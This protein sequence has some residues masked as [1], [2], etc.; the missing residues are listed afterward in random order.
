MSSSN[1]KWYSFQRWHCIES[2]QTTTKLKKSNTYS[3]TSKRETERRKKNS[4][5]F[6]KMLYTD[7]NLPQSISISTSSNNNSRNYH[8]NNMNKSINS[9][10]SNKY[11]YISDKFTNL[12][13]NSTSSSISSNSSSSATNSSLNGAV[14][15]AT[16]IEPKYPMS[17]QTKPSVNG[18]APKAHLKNITNP[19]YNLPRFSYLTLSPNGKKN[20]RR[21]SNDYDLNDHSSQFS[22]KV[23]LYAPKHNANKNKHVNIFILFL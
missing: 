11:D 10:N 19:V 22:K 23:D 20:Q 2:N 7:R 9:N 15:N 8:T 18:T 5:A 6:Q 14:C 3:Q 21:T 4:E 1:R 12:Q 16:Y 13:N 17:F